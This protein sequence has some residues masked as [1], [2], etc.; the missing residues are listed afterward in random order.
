MA[1]AMLIREFTDF[2][3][4]CHTHQTGAAHPHRIDLV[5]TFCNMYQYTRFQYFMVQ[6][7]SFVLLDHRRI[8]LFKVPWTDV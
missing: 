1:A 7:F 5:S 8:E 4:V 2:P 6:P 3:N